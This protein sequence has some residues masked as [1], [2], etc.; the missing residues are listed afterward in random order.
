MS[1]YILGY[2]IQG[3]EIF[4][5]TYYCTIP[6]PSMMHMPWLP[7]PGN[8]L[9]GPIPAEWASFSPWGPNAFGCLDLTGNT[10]LCGCVREIRLA[11]TYVHAWR[12]PADHHMHAPAEAKCPLP[13]VQ[14]SRDRCVSRLVDVTM[15]LVYA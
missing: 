7:L 15:M 12:L 5:D 8:Q 6:S 9:S 14:L 4:L 3:N 11:R 1:T 13:A 10:N 2:A